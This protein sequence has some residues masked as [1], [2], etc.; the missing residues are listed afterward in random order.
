MKLF[1]HSHEGYDGVFQTSKH[2]V[3]FGNQLQDAGRLVHNE[4]WYTSHPPM[5]H[6]LTHI[7]PK[8]DFIFSF[9]AFLAIF[10]VLEVLEKITQKK[11]G[12][13]YRVPHFI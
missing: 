13:L 12:L 8:C 11:K 1:I 5:I 4:R 3:M 10:F 9:L 6:M 2:K 7:S